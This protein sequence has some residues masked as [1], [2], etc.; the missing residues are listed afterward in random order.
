MTVIRIWKGRYPM[1]SSCSHFTVL[2]TYWL[3]SFNP[4]LL[5]TTLTHTSW[6]ILETPQTNRY[7]FTHALPTIRLFICIVSTLVLKPT[8]NIIEPVGYIWYAKLV[9]APRVNYNVFILS[10]T[11]YR[12]LFW[13]GFWYISLFPKITSSCLEL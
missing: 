4:Y 3:E 6:F 7:Q 9:L 5:L 12:Y 8:F 2:D 10:I 11:Y 13:M 1:K